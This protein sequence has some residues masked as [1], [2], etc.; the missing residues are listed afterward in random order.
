MT[1]T[2]LRLAAALCVPACLLPVRGGAAPEDGTG[3][4]P[5]A[6]TD[7][8]TGLRWLRIPAGTFLMGCT[9]GDEDARPAHRVRLSA[10]QMTRYEVTREQYARYMAA[11]SAP[12]PA[13]WHHELFSR[14]GAP[15]VGVSWEEA[16]SYAAWAGGR[17]PTEAEWE[18]AARGTDGRHYPWGNEPPDATRAVHHLDIGFGGTQPVGTARNSTGPFGVNDQAG[19]V[20]EWCADWYDA[21]YYAALELAAGAEA[22]SAPRGPEGG[23][24]RVV[25]GGA[26]V[27]LPD[28]CRATARAKYPPGSRST[29]IGIRVVR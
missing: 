6:E 5:A 4:R 15:V 9:D 8:R 20:F 23:K 17:L 28:A 16:R 27:S 2:A 29:L 1:P 10:F 21:G 13:Q 7:A 22:A 18:Y 11:T 24:E 19:S 14:A 26:W 25:R 12:E 3:G